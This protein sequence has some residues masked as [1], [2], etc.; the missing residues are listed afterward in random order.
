MI[1]TQGDVPR[2]GPPRIGVIA[3]SVLKCTLSRTEEIGARI[4]PRRYAGSLIQSSVKRGTF[5]ATDFLS[6]SATAF[7][8][9]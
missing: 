8:R 6:G 5:E 2:R 3:E 7:C 9:E 4:L 1:F